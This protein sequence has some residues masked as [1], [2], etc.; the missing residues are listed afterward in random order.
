MVNREHQDRDD[1][2]VDSQDSNP[3]PVT[4]QPGAH[5]VGTGVGAAGIGAVSTAVGAVLG[6]PIG[7]V[8]GAVVGSVAGGL[9]GKGVAEAVNPTV[10]EEYWRENHRSRS[11]VEE[12]D[13]YENYAPA[14]RTGYEGYNRYAE[15]PKSYE[16]VEPELEANYKQNYGQTGLGWDK[17]KHATRDAYIKLYEERLVAS[18]HRDKVG[19][20]GVGKHVET[21]TA[22]V[23]VPVEKER[24]IVERLPVDS[25]TPVSPG[26]V[27]FGDQTVKRVELYE[28]TPQIQK[29]AFV[30]EEVTVR[31]EI[32]REIVEAEEVIRREQLDV[33]TDGQP[34]V[35]R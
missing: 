30:R 26:S 20:V 33:D 34:I 10:E 12:N 23:S 4:G 3:D 29:E 24:A 35:E 21:E 18:K 1:S 2:L 28:E 14:Y 22:R 32:D 27:T 11:Y 9:V 8:V 16:E 13:A 25:T 7:A 19:E 5:P 15:N 17:A 31:K 6:G